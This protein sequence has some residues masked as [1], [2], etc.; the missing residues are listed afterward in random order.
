[1]KLIDAYNLLVEDGITDNHR[2]FAEVYKLYGFTDDK[3]L[4]EYLDF[5][6]HEPVAWMRGFPSKL[7]TRLAF[8]KPKTALIKL[9]KKQ[10]VVQA[11]GAEYITRIHDKVWS[12]FKNNVDTLMATRNPQAD[13]ASVGS[14]ESLDTIDTI[15]TLPT[16]PLQPYKSFGPSQPALEYEL[17]PITHDS[18]APQDRVEFLKEVLLKMADE[19]PAGHAAAFRL[20][21]SRVP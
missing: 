6:D 12:T 15:E 7:A 10:S 20:L 14:A 21:V 13:K 5:I 17:L 4:K 2:Y 3:L 19:L 11:L 18:Y 1:M 16:P 8:A 9:L